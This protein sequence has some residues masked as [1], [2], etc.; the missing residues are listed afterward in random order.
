MEQGI[1]DAILQLFFLDAESACSISLRVEI[2]DQN[3][4]F[5][6]TERRCKIYGSC[7]LAY[8]AFLVDYRDNT[9]VDTLLRAFYVPKS[10]NSSLVQLI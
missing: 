1:V 6:L 4:V 7:R 2:Y 10:H 9:G 8:T 5:Q 3:L